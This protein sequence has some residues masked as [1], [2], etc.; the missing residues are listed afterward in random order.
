MKL[1]LKIE[2]PMKNVSKNLT[3]STSGNSLS[4]LIN[5]DLQS[6]QLISIEHT[7]DEMA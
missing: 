1:K 5:Y 2:L 7:N 4:T 3:I 6:V